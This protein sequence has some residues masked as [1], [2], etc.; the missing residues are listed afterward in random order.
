MVVPQWAILY[1]KQFV[2]TSI[3]W[4][5]TFKK[6]RFLFAQYK[7]DTNGRYKRSLVYRLLKDERA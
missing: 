3:S 5:L 1:Q 2:P 6:N 7:I 4:N